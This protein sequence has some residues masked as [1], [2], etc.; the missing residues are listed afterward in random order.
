MRKPNLFIVGAPKCGTTSMAHYLSAH[1]EIFMEPGEPH[2]FGHDIPY[3]PVRMTETEYL[4]LFDGADR[5][6][7]I[8]E[9]SPWYLFSATAAEEIR[10]FQPDARI[11]IQIRNPADM[12]YSLH[13]H[14]AFHTKREDILDFRKALAAEPDRRAGRRIPSNARFP[15]QLFYSEIPRYTAQIRRYVETFGWEKVHVIVYDDLNRDPAAV[16][17]ATLDFLEVADRDFQPVFPVHNKARPLK[18]FALHNTI[19]ATSRMTRSIK[20]ALP[21]AAWRPVRMLRDFAYSWNTE[22]ASLPDDLRRS[23]NRQ[24]HDEVRALSDLLNRDLTS[25]TAS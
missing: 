7:L 24:F 10:A 22:S 12:L 4:H 19:L 15:G 13:N 8:G 3:D 25:W 17:R 23:L 2:F 6:S 21:E 14:Y 20:N 11:I 5:E 18:S 16:Y 9:K 1:P